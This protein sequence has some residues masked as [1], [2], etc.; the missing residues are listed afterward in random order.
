MAGKKRTAKPRHSPE[1]IAQACQEHR[2]NGLGFVILAKQ[3]DVSEQTVRNWWKAYQNK[4]SAEDGVIGQVGANVIGA[5]SMN[6][7]PSPLIYSLVDGARFIGI[8][9]D[10]L[11]HYGTLGKVRLCIEIHNG[12]I[13]V[14]SATIMEAKSPLVSLGRKSHDL[15]RLRLLC[16]RVDYLLLEK[17]DCTRIESTG[18]AF[19]EQFF[20]GYVIQKGECL[21]FRGPPELP[22]W[23]QRATARHASYLYPDPLRNLLRPKKVACFHVLTG[24]KPE[25]GMDI[26]QAIGGI[27]IGRGELS[28]A[29]EELHLL[30]KAEKDR[31]P[32]WSGPEEEFRTHDNRS[33]LLADLDQA[34]FEL[35]GDF[36]PIKAANCSTPEALTDYLMTHFGFGKLHAERAARMLLPDAK[37]NPIRSRERPYRAAMLQDLIALWRSVCAG[38]PFQKGRD[39]ENLFKKAV[40]DWFNSVGLESGLAASVE[41][42]K[43]AAT[44]VMPDNAPFNRLRP[45]K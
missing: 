13:P 12:L 4:A 22:E 14:S 31:R 24:Y 35:W 23:L 2:D 3:Y 39:E 33:S 8:T 37:T 29:A 42:K 30:A 20:G 1:T 36:N 18:S 34:A 17:E 38:R 26:D 5:V 6:A 45:K 16:D 28:V 9:A 41:L 32:V 21:S 7:V 10:Q 27:T 40:E 15:V 11:L 19:R 25:E 43:T 44:L